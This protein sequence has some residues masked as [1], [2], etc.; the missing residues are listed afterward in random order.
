LSFSNRFNGFERS[1]EIFISMQ[2]VETVSAFKRAT[3]PRLKPGE[4]QRLD[5][6]K[7]SKVYRTFVESFL[8]G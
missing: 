6:V 4:N 1:A 7:G 2:T 5:F 8:L 3:D